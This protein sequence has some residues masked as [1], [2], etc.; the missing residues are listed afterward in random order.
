M[1]FVGK[2]NG[3]ALP[4]HPLQVSSWVVFPGLIVLFYTAHLP[5]LPSEAQPVA[6]VLLGVAYGVL[7]VAVVVQAILLTGSD[8]S[9]PNVSAEMKGE[10][11]AR[12]ESPEAYFCTMCQQEVDKNSKHC[13]LCDKC[14]Q[15]FD[16]HCKWL[17]NCI[18]SRNYEMF[19]RALGCTLAMTTLQLLVGLAD[20]V[21]WGA[22]GPAALAAHMNNGSAWGLWAGQSEGAFYGTFVVF[23]LFLLVFVALIAQ[24]FIFHAQIRRMDPPM[25]TYDYIVAREKKKHGRKAA[26][27]KAAREREAA[28]AAAK[29]AANGAAADSAAANDA[30]G[31]RV[32]AGNGR[33]AWGTPNGKKA[34]MDAIVPSESAEANDIV[35]VVAGGGGGQRRSGNHGGNHAMDEV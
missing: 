29:A 17:N 4:W 25:T 15:D 19:F 26:D 18:G 11:V 21:V 23:E 31:G 30:S 27:K 33:K 3:W 16:H 1:V 14:V 20:L 13:R 24:L 10:R 8:S 6:G 35:A 22:R 7:C 5:L 32:E 12:S 2:R 9:D 28:A 34:K